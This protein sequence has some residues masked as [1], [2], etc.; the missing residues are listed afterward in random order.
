MKIA[1]PSFEPGGLSAKVCRRF[2]RCDFFTIAHYID[3]K[4]TQ[5]EVLDNPGNDA[6]GGAGPLA[7]QFIVKKGVKH[8]IGG[9]YGPNAANALATGGIITYGYPEN[10]SDITVKRILE[11]FHA[12][13][14][15]I[16]TSSNNGK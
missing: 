1:I 5:I 6:A 14:L 2:G 12:N 13:K 7:T 8:V 4:L 9:D 11:L 3:K 16:V 10:E 15:Q